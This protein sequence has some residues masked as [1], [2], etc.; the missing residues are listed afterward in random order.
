MRPPEGHPCHRVI[1]AVDIENSTSRTDADKARLRRDLYDL[2]EDVLREAGI[3]ER[4]HDTFIDRGDGILA[5]FHPVD[6]VPKTLMLTTVAPLLRGHLEKQGDL[7]LRAVIHAGEV[8][9]DD[10]GCFG[11]AL[12]IGFRLLDARTVKNRL[13]QVTTPLVV[14]VSDDIH[15]AIVRHG[16]PGIDDSAFEPGVRVTVAGRSHRGWIHVP[17]DSFPELARSTWA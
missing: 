10:T 6:H 11:E 3:N 4:D 16:Y 5:L 7:R 15:Q 13:R 2:F 12:D 1:V 14:V 17:A 8:R 9:Y